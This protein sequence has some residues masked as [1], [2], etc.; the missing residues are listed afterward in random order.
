MA[1]GFLI[2]FFDFTVKIFQKLEPPMLTM[3]FHF[4]MFISKAYAS[5]NPSVQSSSNSSQL[6]PPDGATGD[7]FIWDVLQ[8]DANM[9]SQLNEATKN[10]NHM[11]TIMVSM[12][13]K[14]LKYK[15]VLQEIE[16][17]QPET[18][19]RLEQGI[20]SMFEKAE[21]YT[22][23]FKL[24][25]DQLSEMMEKIIEIKNSIFERVARY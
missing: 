13:N 9:E 10:V 23:K 21:K 19:E 17:Q 20:K 12:L 24:I 6:T 15:I 11:N 22:V 18:K 7:S 25:E 8:M 3:L 5:P 4:F 16:R 14:S 2:N 1:F